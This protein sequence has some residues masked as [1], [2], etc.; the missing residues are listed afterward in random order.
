LEEGRLKQERLYRKRMD[1]LMVMPRRWTDAWGVVLAVGLA[2]L[3]GGYFVQV[4]HRTRAGPDGGH[5]GDFR[6]F[7]F[8]SRALLDHTDLYASGDKGYLYPPL[9][10][11]LYTP[12]A[13]L[14]MPHAARAI[15]IV[16][17]AFAVIGVLLAAR[18]YADRFDAPLTVRFVCG[19]ALLGSILNI[20]K[21]HM[22]FQMFQTNAFMFLMFMLALRWLDRRPVLAGLPL[23]V[24][25]NI[26]YLSLAMLPWLIVRRRWKTAGAFVLSAIGF[27]LLPALISG[28]NENL[29]DLSVAYGG[30]LHMV[31]I[32][33]GVEQANVEDITA[34][35]S[36]SITSA[37]ARLT[38]QGLSMRIAMVFAG[39]IALLSLG[40][41][42]MLYRREGLPLFKWPA[43][44][45]QKKQPWKG[46][47]GLEYSALLAASICFSPQTNTK[48]LFLALVVTIPAAVLLLG[49]RR[50]V[51]RYVVGVGALILA[52]CFILP[53]GNRATEAHAQLIWI[54]VGGQCWGLLI[55]LLTLLS[56]GLLQVRRASTD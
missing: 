42:V 48:H 32:G 45:E 31:G 55:G 11:M 5:F 20:D 18:A 27:A 46:T 16:N 30:L 13:R 21:I 33:K 47:I 40:V 44:E 43:A 22:E 14:T 41:V 10:A 17:V 53:P 2:L 49:A 19:A 50:G 1:D 28:W 23:G 3:F 9:I 12:V 37:M 6:H 25:F 8:A 56:V 54:G 4:L 29:R 35:F 34:W 52:L 36:C 38:I 24:I 15:L 51:P 26:K 39:T 7:Y